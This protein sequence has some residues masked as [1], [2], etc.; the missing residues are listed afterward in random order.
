MNVGD[1]REE[2]ETLCP[3]VCKKKKTIKEAGR[4]RDS[5]QELYLQQ[6]GDEWLCFPL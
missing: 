3:R 5:R 4:E 2:E 6:H 1:R